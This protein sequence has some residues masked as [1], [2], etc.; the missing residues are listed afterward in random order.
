MATIDDITAESFWL[1]RGKPM[2]LD[3]IVQVTKVGSISGLP[4]DDWVTY[5][6]SDFDDGGYDYI[7]SEIFLNEF[8][9]LVVRPA[10]EAA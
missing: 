6:W 1:E 3:K 2:R 5:S 10:G 7:P 8:Q 9:L 4:G